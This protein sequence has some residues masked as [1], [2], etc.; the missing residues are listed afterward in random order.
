[1]NAFLDWEYM[2]NI[3]NNVYFYSD[4]LSDRYSSHNCLFVSQTFPYIFSLPY[5]RS[6]KLKVLKKIWIANCLPEYTLLLGLL[7]TPPKKL[8]LSSSNNGE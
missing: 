4:H 2:L 6:K 5:S 1:M 7:H 8:A 3:K